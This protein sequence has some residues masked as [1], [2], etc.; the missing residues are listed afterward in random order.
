[1]IVNRTFFGGRFGGTPH[2]RML[3]QASRKIT[4]V[5]GLQGIPRGSMTPPPRPSSRNAASETRGFVDAAF[6]WLL[7]DPDFSQFYRAKGFNKSQM[8]TLYDDLYV[9]GLGRARDREVWPPLWTIAT[10]TA[11]LIMEKE[12]RQMAYLSFMEFFGI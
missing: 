2:T 6:D 12:D 11:I 8:W 4:A 1:V 5:Y 3:V 7:T 10:P 9:N